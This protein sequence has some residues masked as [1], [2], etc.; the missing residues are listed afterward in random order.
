MRLKRLWALRTRLRI[1]ICSEDGVGNEVSAGV[2]YFEDNAG[3][4]PP[5]ILSSL[6][7]FPYSLLFQVF[8]GI[9]EVR[10]ESISRTHREGATTVTSGHGR[11]A[12][13]F[14]K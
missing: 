2:L 11:C 6:I 9:T 1:E 7:Y 12:H 13:H 10:R 8:I 4:S 14:L 5:P 3:S